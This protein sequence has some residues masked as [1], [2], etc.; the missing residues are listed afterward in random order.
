MTDNS[1]P[2]VDVTSTAASGDSFGVGANTVTYTA[3]DAAGNVSTASFV[4]TV[5]KVVSSAQ[6][7]ITT[8]N[9]P[10]GS[11]KSNGTVFDE[12]SSLFSDEAPTALGDVAG[13]AGER[14]GARNNRPD[15]VA[16][17][18]RTVSTDEAV[19]LDGSGSSDA[20]SAD[21]LTYSWS[22]NGAATGSHTLTNQNQAVATFIPLEEGT[23][24]IELVVSDGKTTDNDIL[25]VTAAD[26]GESRAQI[27]PF[28]GGDRTRKIRKNSALPFV[29]LNSSSVGGPYRPVDSYH[30]N[31]D[32]R[33][34]LVRAT[35][36][37]GF[38]KF[39]SVIEGGLDVY[40][41]RKAGELLIISF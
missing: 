24:L 23:Y 6:G 32:D 4:V 25:I 11:I 37:I 21:N 14:N 10:L 35:D 16:G 13:H 1:S 27:V 30:L 18:D 3:T 41:V 28:T 12:L 34:I 5:F 8:V 2:A 22:V 29:L 39:I 33:E 38:F 26:T 19:V 20:D 40:S 15:A 7:S 31:V 9:V 17:P 36:Q